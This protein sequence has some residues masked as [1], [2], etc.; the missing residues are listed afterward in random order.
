MLEEAGEDER[1]QTDFSLLGSDS[2]FCCLGG[3][4]VYTTCQRPFL[5]CKVNISSAALTTV[6]ETVE[7]GQMAG[8]LMS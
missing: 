2:H 7:G 3:R 6:K 5:K 1:L 8:T 4:V